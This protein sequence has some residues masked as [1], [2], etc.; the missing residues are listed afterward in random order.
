VSELK[1]SVH[2]RAVVATRVGRK[3][4]KEDVLLNVLAFLLLYILL[5]GAG[6]LALALLGHDL[7]TAVGAS[8]AAIGNIGPGLGDVGA[9]DNYGWMGPG[10]H[11]VLMFLM[12]VG[13]LEIF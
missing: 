11:T 5:Y 12:L 13:R 8:A 10:S 6:V 2:P 4:V 9:V 3:V 7:P 1:K